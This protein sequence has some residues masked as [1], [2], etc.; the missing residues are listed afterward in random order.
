L[1]LEHSAQTRHAA[2]AAAALGH[3]AHR[4]LASTSTRYIPET[5]NT[6]VGDQAVHYFLSNFVLLPRTKTSRGFLTYVIPLIK[7]EPP[8]TQLSTS[9]AAV[10][11]AAFGNRPA[12]KHL[13]PMAA[14]YYCKALNL[15]NYAL[16]DPV[17]QRSDQTLVSVLLLGLFEACILRSGSSAI[18]C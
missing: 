8:D 15:I 4:D 14:H 16:R 11:L 12:A 1:K 5:P 7:N 13:L 3:A 17:A 6:S 2:D 9:F 18:P 10:A